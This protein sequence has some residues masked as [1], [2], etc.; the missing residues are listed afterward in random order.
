MSRRRD[1]ACLSVERLEDRLVL[2]ADVAQLPVALG[3]YPAAGPTHLYMNFDGYT[4]P[5]IGSLVTSQ[6]LSDQVIQDT[7]YR[8][9]EMFAPF[10]VQVS[11]LLGN[12]NFD[13]SGDGGT[14]VFVGTNLGGDTYTPDS[15]TDY[16]HPSLSLDHRPNSDSNDMAFVNPGGPNTGTSAVSIAQAL[17]H[18]AGHTFGLAHV[19]TDT[20]PGG[21]FA[22]DAVGDPKNFPGTVGDLMSYNSSGVSHTFFANQSLPL[23]LANFNGTQ[24]TFDSDLT[25]DYVDNNIGY[26]FAPNTQNSFLYL[27]EVLGA[28]PALP[29]F[30]VAH[31]NSVDPSVQNTFSPQNDTVVSTDSFITKAGTIVHAGDYAVEQWTAPATETIQLSVN[32]TGAMTLSPELLAYNGSNPSLD[33]IG[34]T[35]TSMS[36]AVTSGVTYDFVVGGHDG[37]STGTYQLQINQLPSWE[38]LNGSTLSINGNQLGAGA[39]ETL[40]ITTGT[41]ARLLVTL[42]GQTTQFEPGQLSQIAVNS[43]GGNN[44]VNVEKLP[45]SVALALNLSNADTVLF[46]PSGNNLDQIQGLVSVSG[47]PT[48]LS[49]TL[50]DQNGAGTRTY[51]MGASTLTLPDGDTVS[52]LAPA[53]GIASI[54]LDTDNL[55]NKVNVDATPAATTNIFDPA[56]NSVINVAPASQTLSGIN[57]LVIHGTSS[58][59]LT[60]NDQANPGGISFLSPRTTY[61]VNTSSLTRTVVFP[62]GNTPETATIDYFGLA[63]LNLTAGN[64][65]PNTVNVETT[66]VPT[67]VTAGTKTGQINIAPT[68][69]NLD[70]IIGAVTVTGGALNVFD[71]NNPHGIFSHVPT[72]YTVDSEITRTATIVNG[73]P[74]VS[75]QIFDFNVQSLS[76]YTSKSPNVVTVAGV[77]PSTTINSGAA[78]TVTV[79]AFSVPV[80][81]TLSGTV[82]A[83]NLITVNA[84]GGTLALDSSA[85]RS[86]TLDTYSDVF[87]VTDKALV[88]QEH[89]T[90]VL[91]QVVDPEIPPNPKYPPPPPGTTLNASFTYTLAYNQ[92][93]SLAIDGAPISNKFN[94]QSTPANVPVTINTSF[95]PATTFSP[96][97]YSFNQ[98]TI[99]AN[100]SVKNIRG[101]VTLNG[102]GPS[103]SVLIDDSQDT[104]QDKVT[105]T[106][107]QVTS[108]TAGEFFANGGS[109]N[110][111]HLAALT[112][113]LSHAA[114]D[115]VELTPSA[116]TALFINGDPTEFQAGQGAALDLDLAALINARLTNSGP[117]AGKWTFD[118]SMPVT[119]TNMGAMSTHS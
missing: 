92:V 99:G 93:S 48:F 36:L 33:S 47:N 75:T 32:A 15:N 106:G 94:I 13:A 25:Y 1:R 98:F 82:T 105:V 14:T 64:N 67:Y 24:N 62:L 81:P 68:S 53:S 107:A 50:N 114:G 8:T 27:Q 113:N 16:P 83:S 10:N 54:V 108:T 103:D 12:G 74:P 109:L 55:A 86:D 101:Q 11:R 17:A 2:N 30:S 42:N 104:Q 70:G 72:T 31:A 73:A 18:E 79:D 26:A 78:D 34:S 40:T 21:Q 43:L 23:T 19:R 100:G 88:Q 29:A 22:T 37:T 6:N 97:V 66:S 7:L 38:Q 76:V 115:A 111:S 56:A 35:T 71:Q 80:L 117:G 63:T 41:A 28:R 46:S 119:F 61:T 58:T 52:V 20:L 9:Y 116:V 51:G 112:L 45:S 4:L 69:E 5:P 49:I 87:T 84:N 95:I 77:T 59:T 57:T 85:T 89:L 3:G 60:V 65:G 118:N 102:S 39:S 96:A 90:K 91:K 110:Y 44:F